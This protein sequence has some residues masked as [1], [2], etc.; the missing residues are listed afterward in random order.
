MPKWHPAIKDS[1]IESGLQADR[2]GCIRNFNLKDGGNIREHLIRTFCRQPVIDT[3]AFRDWP[4]QESD[5]RAALHQRCREL[6]ACGPNFRVLLR[7]GIK[8]ND[9]TPPFHLIRSTSGMT[10]FTSRR[11]PFGPMV[12]PTVPFQFQTPA[13]ATGKK[14]GLGAS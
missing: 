8:S 11:S 2:V 13:T 1:H 3:L 14:R 6:P 10:P 7:V 5:Y 9:Y 4:L 12:L